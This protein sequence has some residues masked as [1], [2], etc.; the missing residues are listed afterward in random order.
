MKLSQI[1]DFVAI[2]D[3]VADSRVSSARSPGKYCTCRSDNAAASTPA[4]AEDAASGNASVHCAECRQLV[5]RGDECFD[6]AVDQVRKM[7]PNSHEALDGVNR[8]RFSGIAPAV[9]AQMA[10]DLDP[11]PGSRALR[12]CGQRHPESTARLAINSTMG[13]GISSGAGKRPR[14]GNVLS[15]HKRRSRASGALLVRQIRRSSSER[16]IK[17]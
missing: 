14:I 11:A 5:V 15:R 10:T 6:G 1:R 7:D 2:A 4:A 12:I 8:E 9:N 17:N 16:G 13:P 3:H